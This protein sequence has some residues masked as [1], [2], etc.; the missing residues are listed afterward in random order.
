MQC[1]KCKR[2]VKVVC[3]SCKV[4][5][6]GRL[7]VVDFFAQ[8]RAAGVVRCTF[9]PDTVHLTTEHG[10]RVSVEGPGDHEELGL[11]ALEQ[12]RQH[13][14]D[15]PVGTCQKCGVKTDG[16]PFCSAEHARDWHISQAAK[17]AGVRL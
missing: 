5:M 3:A 11:R 12:L 10:R 8:C 4:P 1:P 15:K 9:A 13:T 14:Q 16:R 7:T 6:R 17:R 2:N